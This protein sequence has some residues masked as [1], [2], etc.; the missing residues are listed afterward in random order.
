MKKYLLLLFLLSF[1]SCSTDEDK[2]HYN[3]KRLS[4]NVYDQE[5]ETILNAVSAR[6]DLDLDFDITAKQGK[7]SLSVLNAS[8]N[9]VLQK[10]SAS[11]GY[12]MKVVD[13]E[14]LVGSNIIDE[15]QTEI[16]L[17]LNNNLWKDI[18]SGSEEI[19]INEVTV[20]N[21]FGPLFAT[22][23]VS[24]VNSSDRTIRLSLPKEDVPFIK[25]SLLYLNY[26]EHQRSPVITVFL[27][28]KT[29][30]QKFIKNLNAKEAK[31]AWKLNAGDNVNFTNDNGDKI[32]LKSQL[33]SL[34]NNLS[35]TDVF[36]KLNYNKSLVE[37]SF[38]FSKAP[39]QSV[40]F[41]DKLS[42]IVK[43][44]WYIE[45][46]QISKAHLDSTA[47]SSYKKSYSERVRKILSSSKSAKP[48]DTPLAK[49]VEPFNSNDFNCRIV[50][51]TS[52]ENSDI[53]SFSLK[54]KHDN[55]TLMQILE[56]ASTESSA[57]SFID[58]FGVLIDCQGSILQ[59]RDISWKILSEP[60]GLSFYNFTK[61]SYIV[62]KE[63][64]TMPVV[65]LPSAN[66]LV[67]VSNS[68]ILKD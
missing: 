7:Y 64:Y 35:Q 3:A 15:F 22:V 42:L 11:T 32:D 2:P 68:N 9:D 26:L 10:L 67:G 60:L 34:D 19:L 1:C 40:N 63:G 58:E 55:Y 51:F 6:Y 46:Q 25:K 59:S 39:I 8:I 12:F 4:F 41:S 53:E 54:L 66:A 5:L 21:F 23:K 33:L 27:V 16:S 36:I 37:H 17:K 47:I 14:I 56:N 31:F 65:Y 24:D 45:G 62:T 28:D 20:K 18:R 30:S 61:G 43:A 13:N 49:A 44:D 57:R 29:Q 48:G 50:S 38:S 52:G